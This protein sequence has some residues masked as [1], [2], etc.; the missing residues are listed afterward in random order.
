M[1]VA[2]TLKEDNL[3]SKLMKKKD[4]LFSV[5]SDGSKYFV[6]NPLPKKCEVITISIRV[7]KN[8]E[9][10]AIILRTKHD[11]LETC[12]E[13][14]YT[15]SINN[16]D[17]YSCDISTYENVLH[18][19]F[20]LVCDDVI[21]YYNQMG[22]V[23]YIPNEDYDFKIITNYEQPS[24]VRESV[25]Y[26]ILPDRFFN[27][28]PLND[29]KDFEYT[30]FGNPCTKV[31][32]WN[33]TPKEYNETYCMDFYG[34]DLE[35][36]EKKI[37]YLKEL[38]VKALYLNPIFYAPTIHKYDC[39]DYFMVDPHL[40]HDEGLSK[41]SNA[42]HE[43]NMKLILDV[44]IN[45]TGVCHK[46][47]NKSGDFF[48]LSIGAYN[49]INAKERSYYFFK[50]NNDYDAWV[51]VK[52]LPTLNYTSHE[53]RDIIYQGKDSFI[54]KWMS[55]PY[56]I[57]GWRFDVADCMARNKEVQ[58][59]HTV[60][61]EIRKVI[62]E[63]KQDAY[64][65]CEDWSDCS[66]FLQGDEWDS[67]MNYYGFTRPVREYV[68]EVDLFNRRSKLLNFYVKPTKDNLEHRI[69][70]HLAHLPFV[71]QENQFNLLGSHDTPRLHNNK[72][73]LKNDY[74][75]AVV[76]MFTMIGTPSIYYGDEAS[77]DGGLE[78]TEQCRYPFPWNY[79][80]KSSYQFKLYQTLAN[81]KTKEES[82]KYGGY[83]FI[84]S[85]NENNANNPYTFSFIRFTINEGILVIVSTDDT[86]TYV[87][88][89]LDDFGFNSLNITN[90]LDIPLNY[91]LIDGNIRIKV[92]PHSYYLVKLH[93]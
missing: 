26:Q 61:P 71:I 36:I 7:K 89:P 48:D 8:D 30:Y 81:L 53:L 15:K 29:V 12:Y 78:T 60:W 16:L 68:G 92:E 19:H 27:G 52:S 6:S 51:G 40:G 34:G 13:M 44:S 86:L 57:D 87:D 10:K 4:F 74:Y 85:Y 59:H 77:I 64:I 33:S 41:L 42:L 54:R 69:M 43:N 93:N 75:I 63:E 88:V 17:Y 45:H 72:N 20:Y 35:G 24:W 32:D 66:D 62:K 23:D 50:E 73:V 80:D 39:L 49:N 21:Y 22:I 3:A 25:F 79:L 76:L 67:A 28:N 70:S 91:E 47:F 31:S 58:L 56:I 5:Y 1:E 55:K 83:R 38:G 18:Y 37:P 84:N 65:L 90:L 14:K 82:L 11:G 9:L 2:S 46:W